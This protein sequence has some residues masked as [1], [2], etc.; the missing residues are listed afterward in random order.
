M[1]QYTH[2]TSHRCPRSRSR[3]NNHTLTHTHLLLLTTYAYTLTTTHLLLL[4]LL[5]LRSHVTSFM[6][7]LVCQTVQNRRLNCF[8]LQNQ[9]ELE[10]VLQT[11]NGFARRN[12]TILRLELVENRK[13][14]CRTILSSN[15]F[16]KKNSLIFGFAR[17]GKPVCHIKMV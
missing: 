3:P 10:M 15:W 11:R 2:T 5:L 8:F 16:C 4:L 17:F 6:R 9:F 14:V 13:M 1:C 12:K 7:E